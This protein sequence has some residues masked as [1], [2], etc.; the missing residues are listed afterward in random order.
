MVSVAGCDGGDR[1]RNVCIVIVLTTAGA[2]DH[3]HLDVVHLG[4]RLNVAVVGVVLVASTSISSASTTGLYTR[5]AVATYH[6][7][8]RGVGFL[9]L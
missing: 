6:R 5:Q 7:G 1:G 8:P 2:A 3:S 4:C 9:L